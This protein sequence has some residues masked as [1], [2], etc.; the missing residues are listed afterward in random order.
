M[1]EPARGVVFD[2]DG[3]I[4]DTERLY[5]EAEREMLGRRGLAFTDA[6]AAK[7]MGLPGLAAMELLVEQ[8]DLPDAP[9]ALYDEALALFL[10]KLP[11]QLRFMPG[12]EDLLGAVERAGLPRAV[13]TSTARDLAGTMLRQLAVFDRFAFVLTRDDVARG[14]PDPEV[15][16]L[17]AARLG[18]LPAE[19]VAIEDSF[20]GVTA[21][22]A[23]GCRTFA[24]RHDCNRMFAFPAPAVEI[25]DFADPRLRAALGLS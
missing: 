1:T 6:L 23:A 18:L 24:L 7:I 20:N 5:W 8:L 22:V 17:A 19:T 12:F 21:A 16:V 25:A 9:Q 10:A 3:V 4:F 14:K 2:M 15:Y 11:A 13:A